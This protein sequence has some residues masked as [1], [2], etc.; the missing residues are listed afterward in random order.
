[1]KYCGSPLDLWTHL[2]AILTMLSLIWFRHQQRCSSSVQ[3][4]DG[5]VQCPLC[6]ANFVDH[7]LP[8]LEH[9]ESQWHDGR[10]GRRSRRT[11]RNGWRNGRS[12][13]RHGRWN[14]RWNESIGYIKYDG[15]HGSKH[16]ELID[17]KIWRN[18]G[19][20]TTRG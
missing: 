11:R 5:D 13:R 12:T 4:S 3:I 20:A 10:N 1:M 18:D 2:N 17:V 14:A 6:V 16:D 15:R 19:W 7:R 9:E 8:V